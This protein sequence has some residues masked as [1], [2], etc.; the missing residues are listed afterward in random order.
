MATTD[1]D[2]S[3]HRG[4][5]ALAV[6]YQWFYNG[7]NFLAFKVAGNA[8]HPLMVA[9]LRF[10]LA[11]LVLL[12]YALVRWRRSPASVRELGGAVLIGVTMLVVSQAAAIWARISCPPGWPRCSARPPRF[13]W[14][15]SRGGCFAVRWHADR[16]PALLSAL[17]ASR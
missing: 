15:C 10:S 5:V 17:S 12:P 16:S 13:S 11:A 7:A 1:T 4:L 2:W 9:T 3:M 6:G 8:L 14:P